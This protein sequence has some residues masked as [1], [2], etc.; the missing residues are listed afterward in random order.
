MR[1]VPVVLSLIAV[2][3]LVTSASAYGDCICKTAKIEN[4]WCPQCKVGYVA[5][6]ATKSHQLYN[7]LK[8]E[9]IADAS[10][11]K[12]KLC[13]SA[14]EKDA[15]CAKCKLAYANN[16]KY[17]SMVAYR[18]ARGTNKDPAKITCP[19]CKANLADR[20]WCSSCQIG[21]VGN[22]AFKDKNTYNDAVTARETLRRATKLANKCETCAV[23][24]VT[25][26]TCATC[27]ISFKDG[28]RIGK[29]KRK[30]TKPTEP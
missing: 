18:L 24:M 16:T 6:V 22:I 11:I 25:D 12:C 3:L 14:L 1:K 17:Q 2:M 7:A 23:A 26:G 28:K 5:G 29:E 15:T 4:G 10:K 8:G 27:K 13:K 19:T 21:L 30:E 9:A 20:G